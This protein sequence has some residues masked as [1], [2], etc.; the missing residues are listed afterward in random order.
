MTSPSELSQFDGKGDARK[1]FFLLENVLLK[2]ESDADRAVKLVMYLS[3]PA[4][5]FYFDNFTFDNRPTEDAK[6]YT[7]VKEAMISRFAPKRPPAIVM[8]DAVNLRYNGGD[9]KLFIEKA[10]RAYREAKFNNESKLG[11]IREAIN[12]NGMLMQFALLRG[13]RDYDSF[14]NACLEFAENQKVLT[15][16][17]W[18]PPSPP[19]NDTIAYDALCKRMEDL[20]LLVTKQKVKQTP[21]KVICYNCNE[22]GHIASQCQK[23]RGI[24]PI[25]TYCRKPGHTAD[26]CYTKQRD[27]EINRR[28]Q[29]E[30]QEQGDVKP[31][32]A[33]VCDEVPAIE[34]QGKDNEDVLN[35]KRDAEGRPLP[36]QA[37]VDAEGDSSMMTRKIIATKPR[38][39]GAAGNRRKK[40]KG[41]N[42][43]NKKKAVSEALAKRVEQFDLLSSIAQAP[44][45][46][47]LG[48]LIRGDADGLKADLRKILAGKVRSPAL[49]LQ[50]TTAPHRHQVLRVKVYSEETFAL[51]DSGAIP[52]VMSLPMVERLNLELRPTE[53]SVKVANGSTEACTGV[54]ERVPIRFGEITV[55]LDFLVLPG[56]PYDVIIGAPALTNL[57]ARI[58]MYKQCVR[59]RYKGKTETI[60]L[61]YEHV[62]E[63]DSEEEFTSCSETDSADSGEGSDEEFVL[64]L[65]DAYQG[66]S[67]MKQC[68]IRVHDKPKQHP[69]IKVEDIT[70][71]TGLTQDTGIAPEIED[72][73]QDELREKGTLIEE[74]LAHL[75]KSDGTV[76]RR[77]LNEYDEIIALSLDAIRPASSKISTR[78]S[79]SL[80]SDNPIFEKDRRLSPMHNRIVREEVD[81][82]LEAGII[83]PCNSA[84]AFPVVIATKKDGGPR[85]CVDYR[86]LNRIM[87]ADR[88]PIPFVDEILESLSGSKYFTS[89]DL[90]SGYWQIRMDEA[91]KRKTTF[92]CRYGTFQFEVMPFGLMNAPATFQRMMDEIL[93]DLDFVKVYIDD[94]VIYSK[95]KEDHLMHLQKTL[96]LLH[97]HGLKLKLKK[98]SFMM[99]EVVLLGHVVDNEGVRTDPAKTDH[100]RNAYPP[101]TKRELRSFVG[102]ASYYRRFIPG[103]AKIARPLHEKTS[104]NVNFVWN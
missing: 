73:V 50:A 9:I 96:E 30:S 52:N 59:I 19:T 43:T 25:C 6:D 54:A 8:K 98:S 77:L 80:T 36:K 10:D 48:Q 78:H 38:R 41:G 18:T 83:S 102:L 44:V 95:T 28:M 34:R 92:R 33:I 72:Q 58:D 16:A 7:K 5:D 104:I 46:L 42:K 51:L 27:E 55:Y 20:T 99:P 11:L 90:F 13:A 39:D 40:A 60:S 57:R 64:T 84:W 24:I 69:G 88:W 93:Q 67:R 97:D 103:F 29:A 53:R 26:A 79:F 89:I 85:F 14:K 22:E 4:F 86:K 101:T 91:C 66:A 32:N 61:E 35:I 1:F 49:S 62:G 75:D 31:V 15:S 70:R 12:G 87:V 71:K 65:S 17:T 76:I 56:A 45:G 68:R 82:M 47:T 81:R 63:A 74:K 100:I 3:G 37:R 23:K 21:R 2:E 94:I